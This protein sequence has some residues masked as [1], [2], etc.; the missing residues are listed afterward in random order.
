M[1]KHTARITGYIRERQFV[2]KFFGK[3]SFLIMVVMMSGG[4]LLRRFQLVP[5]G[6]VAVF[7]IGLG[8]SML[9]AGIR[10]GINFGKAASTA[11]K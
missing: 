11:E 1:K 3:K 4:I 6:F 8:A 10:F 5:D 2:L 7:Y 9:V